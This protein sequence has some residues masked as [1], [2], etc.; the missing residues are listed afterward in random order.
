VHNHETIGPYRISD[1]IATGGMG[2]VYRA[3]HIET[4]HVVALKTVAGVRPGTIGSIR[5]E[6]LALL[7]VRHPGVVRIV[8][9][10]MEGG[11]PW[12]AMELLEGQPL[13]TYIESV[14][15]RFRPHNEID[16]TPDGIG[17]WNVTAPESTRSIAARRV[18]TQ[19]I[20]RS[21]MPAGAGPD[22][23]RRSLTIVRRLCQTLAFLHGEGIVHGDLKPENVVLASDGKPVL[24][25]FGIM[26]RVAGATG[27]EALEVGHDGAG[28]LAYMAP[29]QIRGEVT[30]ARA[31][32]YALGCILYELVCGRSPFVEDWTGATQAQ[33]LDRVPIPPRE[34]VDDLHPSLEALLARLLAKDAQHR[35]GY[36]DDVGAELEALG[37]EPSVELSTPPARP[38][39]YRPRFS[40]R[41][42]LVAELNLEIAA[43]R[44]GRGRCVVLTGPSGGGKT[45]LCL[46]LAASAVAAGMQVVSGECTPL[47][48]PGSDRG[49]GMPLQAFRP[50]LQIIADRCRMEGPEMT[51]RLLG[52]HSRV[53][54]E[55]EPAFADVAAYDDKSSPPRL[56]AERATERVQHAVVEVVERFGELW[57]LLIVIDDLQWA[58]DLTLGVV[59]SFANRTD[60]RLHVMLLA[61]CRSESGDT[62]L[63]AVRTAP[64]ALS[65]RLDP[66]GTVEVERIIAGM[67]AR[68]NPPETLVKHL[69]VETGGNP[70]FIAEYLKAAVAEGLLARVSGRWQFRVDDTWRL[71]A[72]GSVEV[73]VARR[74]DGLG[75]RARHLVQ[76]GSVLGRSFG[77]DELSEVAL[78]DILPDDDA[79]EELI[80]RQILV[81]EAPSALRFVHDKI[82]ETAYDSMDETDR[83]SCHGRAAVV[84]GRR[85]A[86]PS[87]WRRLAHHHL[88]S[89]E[90]AQAFEW[91]ERAGRHAHAAGAFRD[92]REHLETA[93]ALEPQQNRTPLARA[94]LR[95]MYAEALDGVGEID[96]SGRQLLE[97]L[98]ALGRPLPRSRFGWVSLA[99]GQGLRQVWYRLAPGSHL[100]DEDARPSLEEASIAASRLMGY[101]FF[102]NQLFELLASVT[103]ATNLSEAAE[104]AAPQA[105]AGA[106]LAGM[107]GVMGMPDVAR[108]YFER[109]RQAAQ[110]SGDLVAELFHAQVEGMYHLHRG[111]WKAVRACVEP[112]LLRGTSAQ[113]AFETEA[114]LM[115]AALTALFTGD[116]AEAQQ[117]AAALR[118][119]ARA[120]GHR[121]HETWGCI[122]LAECNLR[123]GRATEALALVEPSASE[124]ERDGDVV[125]RLNCLGIIA[126]ARLALGD[127]DGALRIGASVE[128]QLAEQPSAGMAPYHLHEHLPAVR[129]A[130][131]QRAID[132]APNDPNPWDELARAARR[133][134]AAAAR[135]ARIAVIARPYVLRH[136]AHLSLLDSKPDRARR[137]YEESGDIARSLSMPYDQTAAAAAAARIPGGT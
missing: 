11:L 105:R 116:V 57:P 99:L 122:I 74:L 90:D 48:A 125:N 4:G 120:L 9:E 13:R 130:A 83:R 131:W 113:V 78:R 29:E 53:L 40:G 50:L 112:A 21:R 132:E 36:A 127:L 75:A 98:A 58:D 12:H 5:R 6:I 60:A 3:H 81:E 22:H 119:S 14:W 38:Y 55:V 2:V 64:G 96:A 76:V 56:P 34:L 18:E 128:R 118:Q 43:T 68:D 80:S 30:D 42:A 33:R 45:R 20:P 71:V 10:G 51:E 28:T 108:G 15:A 49:V 31:D 129:L 73:L 89:G 59:R 1:T 103:L 115:P 136:E 46:E 85:A 62:A 27:R 70:F 101:Y 111:D 135:Y 66:L 104:A 24:V 65:L 91:A 77:S 39:L 19:A 8:G 133:A 84:L 97:A 41:N 16:T 117:H 79:I 126:G 7:R 134:I 106:F 94:Q 32:L 121:M 82:R 35:P 52:V 123:Q 61:T 67:T 110:R 100:A 72:P 95:R 63:D 137:L 37:G 93:C 87:V 107:V 23:Q 109:S 102:R 26:R 69:A 92:A 47:G 25:D 114:L 86:D 54:E 88:Q 44:N 124:L 17:S